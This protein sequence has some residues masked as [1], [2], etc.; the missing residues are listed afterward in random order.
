MEYVYSAMLLHAAGKKITE[1][2]IKKIL[3]AAGVKSDPSKAKA[4]VASLDGVNI[5]EA[6]S[7]AVFAPAPAGSAPAAEAPSG[8]ADKGKKKKDKKKVEEKEEEEEETSEEAAAE[9]LSALFG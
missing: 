8:D 6:I 3:D 9:G 7:S 2:S 4:L 5:D 1:D